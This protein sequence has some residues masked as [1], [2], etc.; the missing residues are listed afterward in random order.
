MSD[1][2]RLW[3]APLVFRVFF[4]AAAAFMVV[5]VLLPWEDGAVAIPP[6]GSGDYRQDL[7]YRVLGITLAAVLL[8]WVHRA[9]MEVRADELALRYTLSSRRI[10]LRD[11]TRVTAGEHGL[12]IET[13]DGASYG[14][15]MFIG[16]KSPLSSLLHRRARA[17][18]IAQTIMDARP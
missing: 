7:G 8:A 1:N 15:P 3:R 6:D 11:I 16:E 5:G 13:H 14:S 9:R 12:S 17:D 18:D 4:T 10:P 2:T